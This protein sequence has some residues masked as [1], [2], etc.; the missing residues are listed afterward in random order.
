MQIGVNS[1]ISR[2]EMLASRLFLVKKTLV[3][4]VYTDITFLNLLAAWLL[5]G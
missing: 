4:I 1:A 2:A 3:K 5:N